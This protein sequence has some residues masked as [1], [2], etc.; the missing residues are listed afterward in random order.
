MFGIALG[1]FEGTAAKKELQERRK[2]GLRRTG[3]GEGGHHEYVNE[4]RRFGRRGRKRFS[5]VG[6]WGERGLYAYIMAGTCSFPASAP[7]V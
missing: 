6:S 5:I 3:G 2:Q 4:R 1:W 7:T